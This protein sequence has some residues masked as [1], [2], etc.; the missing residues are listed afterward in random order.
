MFFTHAG[1]CENGDIMVPVLNLTNPAIDIHQ[2]NYLQVP[3]LNESIPSVLIDEDGEAPRTIF[4]SNLVSSS[5]ESEDE[6][7]QNDKLH[8]DDLWLTDEDENDMNIEDFHFDDTI[9]GPQFFVSDDPYEVFSQFLTDDMM[10]CLVES[11]NTFMK[12]LSQSNRPRQKNAGYYNNRPT[13]KE[14]MLKF[15]GLM[16]LASQNKKPTQ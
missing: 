5:S 8:E 13:D 12:L 1:D 3:T 7:D 9:S 10:D 16:F 15:I 4:L 14:E 2:L 6:H 11:T